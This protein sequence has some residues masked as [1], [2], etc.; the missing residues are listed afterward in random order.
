VPPFNLYTTINPKSTK[1][2]NIKPLSRLLYDHVTAV[3]I[4]HNLRLRTVGTEGRNLFIGILYGVFV[5][6]E[7]IAALTS[8]VGDLPLGTED[9]S[10][11]IK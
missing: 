4:L 11:R 7:R 10:S 6:S 5:L 2:K 3:C 1:P 8:S 9:D